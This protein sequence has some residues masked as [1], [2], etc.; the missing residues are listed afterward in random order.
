MCA[1]LHRKCRVSRR[2]R[3][4]ICS[5]G[6]VRCRS[7]C[8]RHR[9]M[10]VVS[11]YGRPGSRFGKPGLSGV[12][13]GWFAV[14]RKRRL[15]IFS[16]RLGLFCMVGGPSAALAD[17]EVWGW[18]GAGNRSQSGTVGCAVRENYCDRGWSWSCCC[19]LPAYIYLFSQTLARN[20]GTAPPPPS[21]VA[22]SA[23]CTVVVGLFFSIAMRTFHRSFRSSHQQTV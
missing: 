1:S 11:V 10:L 19:A 9:S 18:L 23:C 17:E 3:M 21:R 4:K 2:R 8:M 15:A 16:A 7:T 13:G 12:F 20:E 5:G 14:R 6:M 22:P